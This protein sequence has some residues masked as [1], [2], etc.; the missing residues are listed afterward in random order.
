[1]G[2]KNRYK[3]QIGDN[4]A[5]TAKPTVN[6]GYTTVTHETIDIQITKNIT[7][8]TAII[9]SMSLIVSQPITQYG[10]R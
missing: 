2:E 6:K 1:M 9:K 10:N 4:S 5:G 7:S 8:I 3:K